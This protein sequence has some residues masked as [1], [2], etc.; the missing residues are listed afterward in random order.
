MSEPTSRAGGIEAKA[1][2]QHFKVTIVAVPQNAET[3][4]FALNAKSGLPRIALW[5][6]ADAANAHYDWLEPTAE[7]YPADIADVMREAEP[8][9]VKRGGGD[10]GASSAPTGWCP[11]PAPAPALASLTGQL[12][13]ASVFSDI[14][15][16][17]FRAS[18]ANARPAVAS[19]APS[20]FQLEDAAPH[21]PEL[22]E[23][24]SKPPPPRV[25]SRGGV[26]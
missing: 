9:D 26:S 10:D 2:A 19:S 1:C 7:G 4:A 12:T 11:S 13:P 25:G 16:Y 8:S 18:A 17:F 5:F 22:S 21:S 15:S 6:T 23:P 14:R 20:S 24:P 3:P